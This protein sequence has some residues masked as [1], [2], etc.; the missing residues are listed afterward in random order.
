MN[1]L[2]TILTTLYLACPQFLQGAMASG[3]RGVSPVEDKHTSRPWASQLTQLRTLYPSSF[4][5]HATLPVPYSSGFLWLHELKPTSFCLSRLPTLFS[6]AGLLLA[7]LY[8]SGRF[9]PADLANG[10]HGADNVSC[11]CSLSVIPNAE[12]QGEGTLPSRFT[13]LQLRT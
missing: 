4:Q 6:L 3:P 2:A 1:C 13:I 12:L 11:P 10:S 9:S 5:A 8:F 7:R